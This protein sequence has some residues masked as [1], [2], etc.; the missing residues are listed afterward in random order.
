MHQVSLQANGLQ[1]A[2]VLGEGGRESQ[3][4]W[5]NMGVQTCLGTSLTTLVKG[6]EKH[7]TELGVARCQPKDDKEGCLRVSTDL[8]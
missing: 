6:T 1:L 8:A 2:L 7:F 3:A 5:V 4:C